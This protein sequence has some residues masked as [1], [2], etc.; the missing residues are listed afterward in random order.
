MPDSQLFI[1]SISKELAQH[2]ITQFRNK[3]SFGDDQGRA[4]VVAY[5]LLTACELGTA[6][7]HLVEDVIEGVLIILSL[8]NIYWLFFLICSF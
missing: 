5:Q 1:L 2:A 3:F 6:A 8:E 4:S 7:E